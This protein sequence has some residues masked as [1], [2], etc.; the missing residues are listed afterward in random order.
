M[1]VKKRGL[2]RGLDALLGSATANTLP[3]Q[4]ATP[5]AAS[6]L[7]HLSLECIQRGKYQPDRKSV[8]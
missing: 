2:G 3:K 7:Q 1:A 5:V 6:E 4:D 8:V